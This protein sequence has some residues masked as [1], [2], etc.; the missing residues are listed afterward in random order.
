MLECKFNYLNA[1]GALDRLQWW[2]SQQQLRLRRGVGGR[3][4]S[5]TTFESYVLFK[6]I[7]RRSDVDLAA[8]T[9]IVSART[10][11]KVFVTMLKAV[12]VIMST[13]QPWPS[14]EAAWLA[15]PSQT[16]AELGLSDECAVFIADAVER[17]TERPSAPDM[18]SCLYSDYKHFTSLKQL[19]VAL[20]NGLLM[21]TRGYPGSISD[22][23][24]VGHCQLGPLLKNGGQRPVALLFDKGFT[25]F[26]HVEAYG[27]PVLTP[28]QKR[29]HQNNFDDVGPINRSVAKHRAPIEALFGICRNYRGFD[30][31]ICLKAVDLADLLGEFVRCEINMS[32]TPH[33]WQLTAEE[34]QLK[35]FIICRTL[36]K[37]LQKKMA[38]PQAV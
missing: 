28:R 32:T 4:R 5:L 3:P 26:H 27:V 21:L 1:R 23:R 14:L 22:N 33:G 38:V 35:D 13:H 20:G 2:T 6:C 8:A 12:T 7:A 11:D 31:R 19:G 17:Q 30:K 25:Q 18:Q 15:T 9:F 10:A 37:M 36:R 29:T 16:R 34:L 24:L